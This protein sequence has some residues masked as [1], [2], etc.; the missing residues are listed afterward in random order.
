[1][2]LDVLS[3]ISEVK[4]C[5]AY[6]LDGEII[7]TFPLIITVIVASNHYT[8]PS[9]LDGRPNEYKN[10]RRLATKLCKLFASH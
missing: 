8:N 4:I 6:E 10:N 7:S 1:M 2:L 3:G 5:Y 9:G